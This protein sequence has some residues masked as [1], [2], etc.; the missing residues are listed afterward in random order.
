MEN[1][2]LDISAL[3]FVLVISKIIG[4]LKIMISRW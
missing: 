3:Y 4:D 2:R 1:V